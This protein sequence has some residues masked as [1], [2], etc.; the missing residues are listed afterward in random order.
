[1]RTI[2]KIDAVMAATGYSR[3][4]L[5]RKARD[6]EDAF[7]APVACGKNRIGWF[8]DEIVAW[9]ESRPRRGVEKAPNLPTAA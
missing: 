1:M 2:V 4:Q 6:P 8:E 3:T 7:P 5:W 9:Q